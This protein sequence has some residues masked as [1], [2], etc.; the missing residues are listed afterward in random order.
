MKSLMKLTLLF[1]VFVTSTS[2]HANS[3]SSKTACSDYTRGTWSLDMGTHSLVR[4]RGATGV[5]RLCEPFPKSGEENVKII[6]HKGKEVF[7]EREMHLNLGVFVDF[8]DGKSESK[9]L[10]GGKL[11]ASS[12]VFSSFIPE[13]LDNSDKKIRLELVLLKGGKVLGEGGL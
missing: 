5:E 3:A 8:R 6:I 12:L 13:R 7:F 11:A 9:K 10:S 2:G 4:A 1:L